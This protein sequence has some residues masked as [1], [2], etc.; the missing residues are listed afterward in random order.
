MALAVIR[1]RAEARG[2]AFGV[3]EVAPEAVMEKVKLPLLAVNELAR[4]TGI[5]AGWPLNR[6]LVRC[7]D[8]VVLPPNPQ[9]EAELLGEMIALAESLTPD[10]EI[11]AKDTLLLDLSR[12][13]SRQAA[14]LG[15]LEMSD[16]ELR[17]VTAATPDLARLA[18]RHA[19]CHGRHI[20][21]EDLKRLPLELL[22]W[23]PGGAEMLPLLRDW[24]LSRLG[25]FMALPRQDLIARLGRGAGE[26]HD[27]LHAKTCR[28]LRLYRPPESMAQTME[29][30]DAV[31]SSEPLVFAFKRLL[32]ALSARLAARHVAVRELRLVFHLESGARLERRIRLPE[33]RVA[34]EDLLRPI[35]VLLDALK[36][37]GAILGVTL[38][39]ETTAPTASQRDWFIRQLPRPEQWADTLARLEGLLGE[40]RVGIPVP[41]VGHRAEDFRLLPGD[42]TA[43]PV[44]GGAFPDSPVP[45]HRF[46]PP[47]EV[48]VAHDAGPRPLALLTGPHRGEIVECR[49]PFKGSGDWWD[50]RQEWK[51]LEWDVR[52][53]NDRLLRLAFLPPDRWVVE[54]RYG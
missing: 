37:E 35:L 21:S 34:E 27:L 33:P 7:P 5:E 49:G 36:P 4:R 51:R 31:T 41:P 18:V 47:W 38:D 44:D 29:F 40:G 8:L 22:G 20:T 52:L 13:T 6:A 9:G 15:W 1:G 30:E 14:G 53:A 50:P 28:L 24:G 48:A 43:V 23:L 54:G 2:V 10:I 16:G 19:E 3:L 17:H 32:H 25:D 11:S 12:S 42:G 26:W 46:R 45:L 39:A